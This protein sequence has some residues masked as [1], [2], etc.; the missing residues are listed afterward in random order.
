[1]EII[2]L[3]NLSFTYPNEQKKAL[4]GVSLNI[5]SGEFVTVCG[6]SGCGKS[7]LLRMLKP[8]LSP[9][10][11]RDGEII[12]FSKPCEEIGERLQSEKIGFVFQDPDNQIACDKVWHE[13]AFG[14]ESLGTPSSEI[15]NKTAEI[16]SYF[17]INTW[18]EK[19]TSEL[20][21]GQK[22]LLSLASVMVMNPE[23][24]ILD[25]PTS[26]LDPIA[27]KRFLNTLS[28]LNKDFGITVILSEHRLEDAFALSDRAVVMDSGR[29]IYDG[30]PNEICTDVIIH[31]QMLGAMPAAVRV[32]ASLSQE[33]HCPVT[34]REG[35]KYL[36]ERI[37][38]KIEF[39]PQMSEKPSKK[40]AIELKEVCF[41]Y[42]KKSD[43]IIKNLSLKVQEGEFFALVGANGAGKTTALSLISGILK[44]NS[45]KIKI[46]GKEIKAS[47]DSGIALMPQ[48]PQSLFV[49]STVLEDLKYTAEKSGSA[50]LIDE[51]TAVCELERLLMRHPY[52][53]SGGEQQRAALAIVLLSRPKIIL[54]DEPTK[55]LDAHFK[56]KLSEIIKRL[57][58]DGITV[59]AVSHDIEFCAEFA[60]RCAMLFNGEVISCDVP[61]KF[62]KGNEYYTTSASV[63]AKGF[64]DNVLLTDDIIKALG[65]TAPEVRKDIPD[66]NNISQYVKE[67]EAD[68]DILHE[69]QSDNKE[70]VKQK[71]FI[72]KITSGICLL[73]LSAASVFLLKGKFAGYGD[74]AYQLATV[75]A[76]ACGLYL[77]I[78]K[79][80]NKHGMQY[81]KREKRRISA[82]SVG[83]IAASAAVIGFTVYFGSVFLHNK[84]YYF[85]S[86]MVILEAMAAF[87][88]SFEKEKPRIAEVVVISALCA[89]GVAGRAAFAAT[90]QFKPVAALVIVSGMCL[91]GETGFLIGA[92][93]AFV[94]NFIF[95]QGVWTPWQMFGF[96]A[97]GLISGMAA[98]IDIIPRSKKTVTVFGF[99]L[100]LLIYG[101]LLNLSYLMTGT[102]ETS[103]KL[104]LYYCLLGLPFDLIHAVSTAFFLWFGAD[105]MFEKLERIKFKYGIFE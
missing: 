2:A 49:K 101:P 65:G 78:P 95:G 19:K 8:S 104:F 16:A 94:S 44:P 87:F 35:R 96:G 92:V 102:E 85:I 83:L 77:I 88:L 50:D 86:L 52:D 80:N 36:S 74:V 13:L 21:G 29:I 59:V 4:D 33:K 64:I 1:M 58:A 23:V 51:I 98:R 18:F 56:I 38:K 62:F 81:E 99:L 25:E 15:R 46:N 91:G 40:T 17:G 68:N 37:D 31:S 39:V 45:G 72:L 7:T 54:L 5:S 27:A 79:K 105:E 53:L 100:V 48:S 89:F 90:P 103:L 10:G 71:K 70:S 14:L 67:H 60:D 32:A 69:N 76:A 75:A 20:S 63:M 97:I 57:N 41:R 9:N 11:Q 47:A 34:V 61:R 93:T 26:R 43:D 22:Q 12:L 42:E 84:K 55:G 3:K 6:K 82:Y 28:E 66:K 73:L 24:I 30:A